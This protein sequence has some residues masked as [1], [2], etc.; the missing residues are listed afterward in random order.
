MAGKKQH[1]RA[2]L[3]RR[4]EAFCQEYALHRN[5]SEAYRRSYPGSRKWKPAALY[6]RASRLLGD[7]KV[8]AR[9]AE[10]EAIAREKANAAFA[11]KAE[12]VIHR[13]ALLASGTVRDFLELDERGQPTI[14]LKGATAAQLYAVNEI[15]VEDIDS[16]RRQ[17][18]RTRLKLGDRIAALR[19]L[20]QHYGLFN[21]RIEHR[22]EHVHLIEHAAREL[23]DR[24]ALLTTRARQEGDPERPDTA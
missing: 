9:V 11:L 10:L 3:T 20:G 7:A 16:G 13:L 12:D 22:H 15:T 8:N 19:L 5:A 2:A 21:D 14:V 24:V 23:H 6:S 18:K 1:P 17:G 4:Q